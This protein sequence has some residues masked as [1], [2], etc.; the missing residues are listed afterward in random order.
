MNN[1]NNMKWHEKW[2]MNNN[3]DN[4]NDENEMIWK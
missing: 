2:I 4:G 3:V 1:N